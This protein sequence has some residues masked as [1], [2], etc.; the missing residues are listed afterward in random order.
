MAPTAG[1][2]Q[3]NIVGSP[4]STTITLASYAVAAG[5]DKILC[6]TTVNEDPDSVSVTS[7]KHNGVDLTFRGGITLDT[8]TAN[9]IELWDL[10]LGSSTPSGDIVVVWDSLVEVQS[11]SAVTLTGAEQQAPEA[12]N[13]AT[14][15]VTTINTSITTLTNNALII[16]G[17]GYGNSNALSITQGGVGQVE[18]SS[19]T[20]GGSTAAH[21]ISHRPTTTAGAHILGWSVSASQRFV[22]FLAA[23]AEVGAS[24]PSGIAVLRRRRLAA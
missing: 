23:Y 3:N 17:A 11:V 22:H 1:N 6:V 16:D 5:D 15:T 4:A 8:G 2:P 14:S 9:R 12:T 13:S 10:Q 18:D 7:V 19:V 21:G 20:V 24:G